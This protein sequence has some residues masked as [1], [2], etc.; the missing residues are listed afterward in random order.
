[1]SL[2]AKIGRTGPAKSDGGIEPL[3][4][5]HLRTVSQ[6]ILAAVAGVWVSSCALDPP[7]GEG[8]AQ[9]LFEKAINSKRG[10]NG[11]SVLGNFRLSSFKKADGLASNV[12]RMQ[13]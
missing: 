13:K 9:Q 7:P 8:H 2:F 6:V 11:D 5:N 1:M 10:D 3:A 12:N 4:A